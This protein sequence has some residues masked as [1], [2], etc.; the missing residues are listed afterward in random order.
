MDYQAFEDLYGE[1][2]KKLFLGAK[3]NINRNAYEVPHE[4]VIMSAQYIY[5]QSVAKLKD[6]ILILETENAILKEQS[7]QLQEYRQIV[8]DIAKK[9]MGPLPYPK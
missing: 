8:L 4:F 9:S 5:S 7:R 3:P 2:F 1:Q 6:K